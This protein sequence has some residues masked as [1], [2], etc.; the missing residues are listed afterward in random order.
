MRA[1]W[2]PILAIPAILFAQDPVGIS[3]DYKVEIENSSVR[4]LRVKGDH[5][6]VEIQVELK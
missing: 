4:V 1:F 3:G 2:L 5:A 6:A